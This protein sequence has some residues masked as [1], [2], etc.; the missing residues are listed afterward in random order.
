MTLAWSAVV[1]DHTDKLV[2]LAL[3]DSANDAGECFPSLTTLAE[4]CEMHRS[5]IKR[6]LNSLEQAGHVSRERRQ[7]QSTV[8]RVHP[9]PGRTES[10]GAEST[11]GRRTESLPVG[12]DSARGRRSV[13]PI[14]V[15]E[16]SIEPSA[17]ADARV[18]SSDEPPP[19]NLNVETWHRWVEYRKQVRRPIKPA[20]IAAAQRKLAG[21][22]PDQAAVVEQSI[23]NGWQGLFEL[24]PTAKAK[25]S[26]EWT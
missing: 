2:L 20:S 23:A 13:R 7:H 12:A 10:L 3:A 9:A 15:I 5:T 19:S 26:S 16:P 8:Y 22:G 4:K 21:F 18:V 24:K 11:G 17:R 25:A 14:T 6:A 1:G